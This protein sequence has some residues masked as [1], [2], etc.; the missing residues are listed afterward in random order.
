MKRIG[1]MIG[2][3]AL[4][5]VLLPSLTAQ[6]EKKKDEAKTEKKDEAK[7]DEAKKDEPKKDDAAKKDE[8]KD[9][10]KKDDEKK[11]PESKKVEKEKLVYAA[12]FQTKIVSANA[13]NGREFTIEVQEI[14]QKK[15]YDM[16]V[17]KAQRMGQLGQQAAQI[18]TQKDP[19]AR[20]T[21]M[22]TYQRDMATYN[23]EVAKRSA[24]LTTGKNM[25][26]KAS[27]NAKV[28]ITFPPVEF[29]DNGFQKKW[30]KKE[31]EAR[32]DKTGLPGYPADFDAIKSGQYIEIYLAK[33]A[34]A[35]AKTPAKK[36]APDD[37]DPPVVTTRQ[38][39]VMI[40]ILS[41]PQQK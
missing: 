17:W 11:K 37:D 26:V 39:Y 27:E 18:S 15:V 2:F 35:P 41:E 34:P 19:K 31:L 20:L 10:E 22:A 28:R 25:E 5:L 40:V 8:K 23:I 14:D 9:P 33:A 7:K 21:S 29:D 6:D 16:N 32:R 24:N 13:E 1:L 30:T 12:K 3:L 4:L 38:E 36:R